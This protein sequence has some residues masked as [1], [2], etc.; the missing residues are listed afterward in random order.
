M[1]PKIRIYLSES[2]DVAAF[3]ALL[4]S[5]VTLVLKITGNDTSTLKAEFKNWASEASVVVTQLKIKKIYT[6]VANSFSLSGKFTEDHA[7]ELGELLKSSLPLVVKDITIKKDKLQM[8]KDCYAVFLTNSMPAWRRI[9]KNVS[10]L[11]SGKLTKIF[12]PDTE[13]EVVS[14][15]AAVKKLKML[16]AKLTGRTNPP[17]LHPR[18]VTPLRKDPKTLPILIE[19]NSYLKEIN[20]VIKTETMNFVRASGK[21]LVSLDSLKAHLK[22]LGVVNNLPTGFTGGQVDER[23]AMYTREGR[24]LDKIPFGAV[25]M[26]PKYDPDKDNT[27]VMNNLDCKTFRYRTL[28]FTSRNKK[29]RHALVREFF[30]KESQ[31]RDAWLLDLKRA[32]SKQQ[33]MAAMTELLFKTACRIGG[34]GNQTKGE[35]TYGLTTLQVRHLQFHPEDVQFN[36]S[37]KKSAEQEHVFNTTTP[38]GKRVGTILETLVKG[39]KPTD[40]VFTFKNKPISRPVVNQYLHSIG[41]EI[42]AHRFRQLAGTKLTMGILKKSPFKAKDEPKQ[43]AVEKW[44]KEELKKVGEVLHHRT[45]TK[46]TG[47]TAL[48]SYID[49]EIVVEFFTNLG[50][51][52]PGDVPQAEEEDKDAA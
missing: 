23:G 42:T 51:R 29:N 48:K 47:S 41:I 32:K 7:Y 44:L 21:T 15:A 26:N 28:T 8:Y 6:I 50:L 4:C 20:H 12:L 34:K 16:C 27:Y 2:A 5:L 13:E 45:G 43:A 1:R 22:K 33:V 39:K 14:I 46:V 38:D 24:K 9:E 36:Y 3:N 52:V 18:E 49:P 37:G 25:V 35:P 11:N 10:I 31:H 19:Y 40:L 17:F 30:K